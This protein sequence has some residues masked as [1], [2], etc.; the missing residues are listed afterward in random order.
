MQDEIIDVEF[1]APLNSFLAAKGYTH[2]YSIGV[3]DTECS[4]ENDEKAVYWLEPL[5]PGDG[6]I[7]DNDPDYY[8]ADINNDE[9]IDMANG[10]DNTVFMIKV[11]AEDLELFLKSQ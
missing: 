7:A 3:D 5:K 1:T 11:P 10:E 8:V 6:R 9:V 4:T 2:I